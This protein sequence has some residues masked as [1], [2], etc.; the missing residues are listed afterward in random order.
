MRKFHSLP[1]VHA[2][3][4]LRLVSIV[5]ATVTVG[6]AYPSCAEAAALQGPL[7]ERTLDSYSPCQ[8]PVIAPT[9][10]TVSPLSETALCIYNPT[11]VALKG[12]NQGADV[13][14][15]T[16]NPSPY[17]LGVNSSTL[18]TIE[19][20]GLWPSIDQSAGLEDN[21]FVVPAE[22]SV[23]LLSDG[24]PITGQLEPDYAFTGTLAFYSAAISVATSALSPGVSLVTSI[25]KCAG[26]LDSLGLFDESQVGTLAS[27]LSEDVVTAG[28]CG[29]TFRKLTR[30]LDPDYSGVNDSLN[31][32]KGV[33]RG[34]D[35]IEGDLFKIAEELPDLR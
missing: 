11:R 18:S 29:N 24:G 12:T 25:Q 1:R 4:R 7:A 10:V 21:Q 31:K 23:E 33:L 30:Q 27:S 9:A 17:D 15:D 19:D 3:I 6:V 8:W 16:P 20:D 13:T 14:V 34:L 26:H 35:P 5:A 32:V 22:S 28:S 2:G